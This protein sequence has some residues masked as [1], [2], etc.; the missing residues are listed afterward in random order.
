MASNPATTTDLENRSLRTLSPQELAVGEFLL[1]DA[2]NI[3][4][5]SRPSVATR[6]DALPLDAAVKALVVQV[7]V[8]MVLRV[9]NNPDGKYEETGDDYSYRRDQAVSTGSLYLSDAESALIGAGDDQS[10]GAWSIRPA[11]HTPAGPDL[12]VMA[13]YL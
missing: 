3:L 11:G 7:Q 5:A 8:A 4:L 1:E 13:G 12:W 9:L 2:W 6:L 10:D